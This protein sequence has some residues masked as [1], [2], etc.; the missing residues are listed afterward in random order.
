VKAL[1]IVFVWPEPDSSAA[2]YR[3]A[4][5]IAGLHARGHAVEVCSSCRSNDY[6]NALH[7]KGIR[8]ASYEPNDSGFDNYVRE[9]KPDLVIFDRFIT[10][11]QFGWRVKENYPTAVRVLDTVD[12]H[13][14]RRT[15]G[16]MVA[17][18]RDPMLLDDSDLMSIDA[19]REL[20]AIYRCDLSLIISDAEMDILRH[21]YRVPE[22]L[23]ELCRIGLPRPVEVSGFDA[24]R[25]FVVI[26]NYHHEPN[27]D[28]FRIL[29]ST[30]WEKIRRH[31]ESRGATGAE[32]HLY[33]AYPTKEFMAFDDPKTGFRVKGKADDAHDTL[34][35][36]RVNL[37][38][39]RFGAGIKGKI[40]DGWTV[41]TPCVGTPIAAE[42]MDPG[43]AFGGAVVDGWEEFARH[44]AEL[45]TDRNR[46]NAAQNEGLR[47]VEALYDETQTVSKAV[48]ALEAAIES[49]E[50]RRARNYTGAMLWQHQHRS[51][52]YFSRWIEAKNS[53]VA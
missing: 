2:G 21:R 49:R 40:A 6:R 42:G 38:P 47:I 53:R 29:Q 52:E 26:G 44:S 5:L 17:E 11:E 50:N 35:N 10:E 4:Q 51:T 8:T 18:G 32:L 23:L 30:L 9:L 33:G 25:D 24:R 19:L 27:V 45:Y 43:G 48:D 1:W 7:S 28:S 37:A 31:L 14:L 46:W 36:Y 41:G 22:E 12:L 20:S 3:T 13:S 16:R 15:R 34:K 39:L